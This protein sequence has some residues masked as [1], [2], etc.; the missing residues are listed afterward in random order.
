MKLSAE[1]RFAHHNRDN[2]WRRFL[3]CIRPI[4]KWNMQLSLLDFGFS[5]L[6]DSCCQTGRGAPECL[7]ILSLRNRLPFPSIFFRLLFLRFRP[8]LTSMMRLFLLAFYHIVGIGL[9]L[10]S[11]RANCNSTI[12]RFCPPGPA[13]AADTVEPA[14][15]IGHSIESSPIS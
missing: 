11:S 12:S 9:F 2:I 14:R 3:G 1:L 4:N 6:L 7:R 8:R 15:H 5:S 13:P 10:E